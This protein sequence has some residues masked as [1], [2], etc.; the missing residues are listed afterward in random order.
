MRKQGIRPSQ[1]GPTGTHVDHDRTEEKIYAHQP[2]SILNFINVFEALRC[3]PDIIHETTIFRRARGDL[4]DLA[5]RLRHG[6]RQ[7][8]A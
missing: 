5:I 6:N 7:R 4:R 3:L 8:L 1:I 2:P